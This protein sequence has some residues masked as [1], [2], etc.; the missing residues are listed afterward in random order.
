[1]REKKG[2]QDEDGIQNKIICS[3]TRHQFWKKLVQDFFCIWRLNFQTISVQT[4]QSIIAIFRRD[5]FVYHQFI[6]SPNMYTVLYISHKMSK[7]NKLDLC[8]TSLN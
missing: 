6:V 3:V 7:L 4:F 5:Y 2:E 8:P 1:M